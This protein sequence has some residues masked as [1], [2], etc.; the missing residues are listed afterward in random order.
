MSQR[1]Y[2]PVTGNNPLETSREIISALWE[3][4][5][6]DA[7]ILPQWHLATRQPE[8]TLVTDRQ[9][10]SEAD[11]FA[12]VMA[13]NAAKTTIELLAENGKKTLGIFLRPCELESLRVLAAQDRIDLDGVFLMSADCL[14]VLPEEDFRRHLTLTTK[15]ESITQEML[16]FAAQ[17]GI[18]PSRYKESCQL[19]HHPYPQDC[20]LHV[21]LFGVETMKGLVIELRDDETAK[22]LS[23]HIQTAPVPESTSVRREKVIQ[24]LETW[25]GRSFGREEE[26]YPDLNKTLSALKQHLKECPSCRSRLKEQ[27]PLFDPVVV[28]DTSESDLTKLEVWVQSCA[29]CG[30]CEHEC[31]QDYPLFSAI[32]Q[33][34]HALVGAGHPDR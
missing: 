30:M 3:I 32:I 1:Q 15:H 29:G 6:L 23:E 28:T 13:A 17:G 2:I 19:C 25:R 7:M 26:R 31:P 22:Q 14:G 16:Q 27:C 11:P 33:I 10:L 18:L 12:P 24:N 5:D 20:D 21:L 9:A 4:R 8:P 34:R